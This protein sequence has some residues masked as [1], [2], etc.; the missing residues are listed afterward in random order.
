MNN[1]E[2]S[3]EELL[4][5]LEKLEQNY[6]K[7]KDRATKFLQDNQELR[8]LNSCRGSAKRKGTVFDLTL[9]DI[10]IPERC[11]YL[12]CLLTNTSNQG[13]VQSNASIDRIDSTKG[14]TKNNIQIISDLANKMKQDATIEQLIQFAIGVLKQHASINIDKAIINNK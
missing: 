2:L 7:V 3:K 1:N 14:Y 5:K 9:E 4:I 6:Q 11:I 10:I 12:D 13:R 8:L